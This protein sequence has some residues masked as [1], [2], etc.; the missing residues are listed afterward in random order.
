MIDCGRLSQVLPKGFDTE[1]LN[2]A[3]KQKRSPN[4]NPH[5]SYGRLF[6]KYFFT[7]SSLVDFLA[8]TPYWIYLG[9]V[10]SDLSETN[11]PID[12]LRILRL[13]RVIKVGNRFV[14]SAKLFYNAL[15]M[16]VEPLFI[17][18]II[19][20]LCL[21]VFGVIFFD[22]EGGKFTVNA[23]YPSGAFLRVSQDKYTPSPVQS[24]YDSVPT[25][26]YFTGIVMTTVGYGDLFPY[27]RAGRAFAVIAAVLGVMFFTLPMSVVASHFDREY[28]IYERKKR[29]R[30]DFLKSIDK[31]VASALADMHTSESSAVEESKS[32][33]E[34]NDD[35]APDSSIVDAH[36]GNS[37]AKRRPLRASVAERASISRFSL[38][39]D[40]ADETENSIRQDTL[41]QSIAA[42][43][44]QV[45]AI[46]KK[47]HV[48]RSVVSTMTLN[49]VA[50]KTS[51]GFAQKSMLDENDENNDGIQM[52]NPKV[53][54]L[55]MAVP[56]AAGMSPSSSLSSSA[57]SEVISKDSA[58]DAHLGSVDADSM[59][60]ST[61]LPRRNGLKEEHFKASLLKSVQNGS[62]KLSELS[63]RELEEFVQTL[64]R[65]CTLLA[66]KFEAC[67]SALEHLTGK[68]NKNST[69]SNN[70]N[71]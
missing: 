57:N 15:L 24:V 23:D 34:G 18:L 10:H 3:M 59:P 69:N 47:R 67:E 22:L 9:A 45:Y 56:L 16:S 33:A 39:R 27:T 60:P 30:A 38:G 58:G 50:H 41:R 26:I 48:R 37:S 64:R 32:A 55:P 68:Q 12:A 4:F 14:T 42:S 44:T 29:I 71:Q 65:D 54:S 21:F 1:E 36:R 28:T 5:Y 19:F 8:I 70:N 2:L 11:I 40:P 49:L 31:D 51:G 53:S 7:L 43:T 17:M 35:A 61:S 13:F 52:T 63:R 25:S 20:C 6:C 66:E 46:K 62:I